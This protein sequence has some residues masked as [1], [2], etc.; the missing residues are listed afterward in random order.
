MGVKGLTW[1]ID[2]SALV[3]VG[4][5]GEAEQWLDRINRGLVQISIPTLLEVGYSATS[6]TDWSAAIETPPI[7][8]MPLAGITPAVE[9]RAIEVQG[10]LA[11]QGHHRAPSVPDLLIAAIGEVNG[12]V[13]LHQDKDFELIAEITE[14]EL[15]RID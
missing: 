9:R 6:P 3:R 13:V 4:R 1:L 12:L 14:Q 2:K 10:I 8:L 7:S 11:D 15:E 5:S